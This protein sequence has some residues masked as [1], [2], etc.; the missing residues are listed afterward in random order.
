[1]SNKSKLFINRN[2]IS[3]L[4]MKNTT[5]VRVFQ[6]SR[7]LLRGWRAN[8]IIKRHDIWFL[9]DMYNLTH[10]NEHVIWFLNDMY[11][12]TYYTFSFTFTSTKQ[13]TTTNSHLR[14]FL[15]SAHTINIQQKEQRQF[16]WWQWWQS[17]TRC[18]SK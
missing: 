5:S 13:N 4:R 2:S 12:L 15:S 10:I 17:C 7:T 16:Q 14:N 1:M 18:S 8:C 9:D 11:H 3:H 6:H